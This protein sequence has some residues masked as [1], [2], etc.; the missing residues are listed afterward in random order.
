MTASQSETML[1]SSLLAEISCSNVNPRAAMLS[2]VKA[3]AI[4]L[5]SLGLDKPPIN[6]VHK[7]TGM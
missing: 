4:L 3:L 5:L 1:E 2:D 7:S 6:N